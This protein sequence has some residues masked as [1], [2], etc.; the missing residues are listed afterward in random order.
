M[1]FFH[2]TV[3]IDDTIRELK[4]KPSGVYVD[5]TLG[6]GGLSSE[7]LKRLDDRGRLISI[8]VDPEAVEYC[9]SRFFCVSNICVVDSNFSD[10]DV[11]LR[12]LGISLV[13]GIVMDLGVSSHQIDCIDRGFSYMNDAPL[14]MRMSK[15]GLSAYDI[16]NFM[17]EDEIS[18]I[19]WKYGEEK[20]SREIARSICIARKEKEIKTTKQL[21]DIIN[22]VIPKFSKG[23]PSKRTFQA[24]RIAVNDELRNLEKAL[25]KCVGLLRKGGRLAVISFHSLEDRIVKN[26]MNFWSRG[27]VCP[28]GIPICVC[29]KKKQVDIVTKR[30]IVP[31]DEEIRFNSRCRSAKLRVCQKN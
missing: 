19:I 9:Q 28:E 7:I 20:F 16:I 1:T 17:D 31:G 4:I 21:V 6:G 27:C 10:I 5:A 3:L 13:D 29:N 26:K 11:V 18:E 15:K 12:D 23:N 14:D 24:I 22:S 8:D 25:D 2:K 30:V